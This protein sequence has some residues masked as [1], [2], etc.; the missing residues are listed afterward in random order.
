MVK[1]VLSCL[2]PLCFRCASYAL[3]DYFCHLDVLNVLPSIC[4]LIASDWMA[5]VKGNF[6]R[7]T[8]SFK[9]RCYEELKYSHNLEQFCTVGPYFG[10]SPDYV[11]KFH[12][13][14]YYGIFYYFQDLLAYSPKLSPEISV[15]LSGKF[16]L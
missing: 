11:T 7:V 1:L 6:H 12:H 3:I 16:P 9:V 2:S 15:S 10:I 14:Q 4:S 8:S 13:L 5:K